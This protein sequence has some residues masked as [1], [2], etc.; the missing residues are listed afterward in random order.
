[1]DHPKF[2]LGYIKYPKIELIKNLELVN[3]KLNIFY[4]GISLKRN[5]QKKIN[6]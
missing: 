2:N 4:Y 3:S 5:F 1:M 6:Y